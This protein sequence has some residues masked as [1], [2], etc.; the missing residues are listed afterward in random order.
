LLISFDDYPVREDVGLLRNEVLRIR[1][2]DLP[3]LGADEYYIHQLIGMIVVI[4]ETGK[5][6]GTLMDILVTGANDVYIVRNS[7][8]QEILLPATDQVIEDI[9]FDKNTIWIKILPG[10]LSEDLV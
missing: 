10:L 3:A 4:K 2:I 8:G 1:A 6:I 5:Q 9:D 7:D